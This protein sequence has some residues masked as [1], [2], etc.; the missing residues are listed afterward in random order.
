MKEI[1]GYVRIVIETDKKSSTTI[2]EITSD[3][4]KVANG[5]RVRLKPTKID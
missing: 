2:T 3:E 1:K 4:V 5:Y